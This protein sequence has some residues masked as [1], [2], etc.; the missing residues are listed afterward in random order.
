MKILKNIK[1]KHIALIL[2]I[3]LLLFIP[4]W[5][6]YMST[7]RFTEIDVSHGD[8]QFFGRESCPYCVKQKNLLEQV[9]DLNSKI[10][11]IDTSTKEGAK[12]FASIGGEGVPYF[13]SK[14]T[15]KSSTGYKEVHELLETL[16]LS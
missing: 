7:E 14:S 13:V 15:G 1:N 6:R 2:F 4:Q 12:L 9:P 3:V 10:Q 5:S 16:G 8:I 11:H